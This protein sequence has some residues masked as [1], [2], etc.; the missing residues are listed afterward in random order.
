MFTQ[1]CCENKLT[2]EIKLQRHIF[3]YIFSCN[4]VK[5]I[6]LDINVTYFRS[7][8]PKYGVACGQKK[9]IIYIFPV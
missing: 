9:L 3:Q 5:H 6:S 4:G 8:H 1:T 7:S 2:L